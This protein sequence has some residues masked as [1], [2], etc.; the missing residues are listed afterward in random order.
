MHE[1]VPNAI[2]EGTHSRPFQTSRKKCPYFM[3]RRIAHV[4]L[5]PYVRHNGFGECPQREGKRIAVVEEDFRTSAN[6][7]AGQGKRSYPRRGKSR[8]AMEG[9]GKRGAPP[10]STG[11]DLFFYRGEVKVLLTAQGRGKGGG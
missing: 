5:P 3:R 4:T 2:Q 11:K 6:A 8:R 1:T 7:F 9:R 10:I